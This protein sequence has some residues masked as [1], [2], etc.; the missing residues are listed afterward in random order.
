[1]DERLYK[2]PST[3]QFKIIDTIGVPHLYCI[4]AKHLEYCRGM[5]LNKEEIIHAESKGARCDICKGKLSY[6]EHE[7]ALLVEVKDKREL[8]DIPELHGY[9]LECKPLCESDGFSG[10]AF[11]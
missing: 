10:F 3:K 1:M 5:Y 4:T 7:I 8:K 9:L 11:K 6:D 2:Y